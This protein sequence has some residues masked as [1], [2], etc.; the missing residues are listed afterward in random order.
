M[1]VLET[2]EM[3]SA[4]ELEAWSPSHIASEAT[5]TARHNGDAIYWPPAYAA[6][7]DASSSGTAAQRELTKSKFDKLAKE[8]RENRPWNAE[9]TEL[10][11]QS[12]YQAIIGMGYDAVPHILYELRR[13]PDHWFWALYAI[14]GVN[15]VPESSEGRLSEMAQAWIDWGIR[16]GEIN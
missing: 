8:W 3:Q 16:N 6:T 11:M 14:T 4:I 9:I 1:I 10:S 15:P 2:M 13:Q 7:I 5:S 12:S